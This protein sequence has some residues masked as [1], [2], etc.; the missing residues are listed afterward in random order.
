MC[1]RSQFASQ[2]VSLAIANNFLALPEGINNPGATNAMH[3]RAMQRKTVAGQSLDNGRG[4][5]VITW[6]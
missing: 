5:F 1:E 4:R 6:E 3:A 2:V